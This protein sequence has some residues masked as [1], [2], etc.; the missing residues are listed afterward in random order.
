MNPEVQRHTEHTVQLHHTDSHYTYSHRTK[1]TRMLRDGAKRGIE[2]TR[3][4]Q[5]SEAPCL[6]FLWLYPVVSCSCM[7]S[8]LLGAS[9][10]DRLG[11][12]KGNGRLRY[13]HKD[14]ATAATAAPAAPA[15][16]AATAATAATA[17]C[18]PL[19]WRTLHPAA[20][21][22]HTPTEACV[23]HK[24]NYGQHVRLI[25][26]LYVAALRIL[27]V[28]ANHRK[29]LAFGFREFYLDFRRSSRVSKVCEA[30]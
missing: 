16:P 3:T 17:A 5:L 24:W 23:S 10:W 26:D 21:G 2:P 25:S 11:D 29:R 9:L 28:Q 20:Q 1:G 8:H 14:A 18:C 13:V 7:W 27:G 30:M 6:T 4:S 22:A 15:A 19:T 12:R